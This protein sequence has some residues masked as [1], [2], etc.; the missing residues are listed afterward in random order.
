MPPMPPSLK[1]VTHTASLSP[2][3]ATA[4]TL[5]SS[6]EITV[7]ISHESTIAAPAAPRRVR[8]SSSHTPLP[9]DTTSS[10]APCG[11]RSSRKST[12]ASAAVWMCSSGT[13]ASAIRYAAEASFACTAV[14]FLAPVF[15]SSTNGVLVAL[16]HA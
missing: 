11:T 3:A 1:K 2:L 8:R 6:S 5:A 14:E 16:S 4:H 13:G 7:R 12:C 15:D 10:L 9:P